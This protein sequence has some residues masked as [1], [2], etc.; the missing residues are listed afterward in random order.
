MNKILKYLQNSKMPDMGDFDDAN[1]ES[2]NRNYVEFISELDK[3]DSSNNER[4][5]S[6]INPVPRAGQIWI[7]KQKYTDQQGNLISGKIPYYILIVN[8]P[9][10]FGDMEFV[11]IQPLSIFTEFSAEDDILV[12]DASITGFKFL[13]ETWNEQPI[14][15][16]I[17]DR[18]INQLDI[19]LISEDIHVVL[20]ED[21]KLFRKIEIENSAYLRHSVVSYLSKDNRM[22]K[23]NSMYYYLAATA[24]LI[25]TVLLIWQPQKESDSKIIDKYL[26]AIAN[27]Y[28][29]D[30]IG[31]E[32][33]LRGEE[34]EIENLTW[35]EC[36]LARKAMTFYEK[37]NFERASQ[38]LDKLL[39]PRGKSN[40]LLFFL[41][42]S[43][44]KSGN[45]GGAI[46]NLKYLSTFESFIYNEQVDYYLAL[47][48]IENG[49]RKKARQLLKRIKD[50]SGAYSSISKNILKE[51]RWF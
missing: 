26:V 32:S 47:A 14:D 5:T 7:C 46:V 40:E 51:L 13:I 12:E 17:L 6:N 2:F 16:S 41:A 23:G 34:C 37:D 9:D 36:E 25:I 24:A 15:I 29:F 1:N 35:E 20:S 10:T 38:I 21:Q 42:I 48:Y 28:V 39:I 19:P 18:Y 3:L 49:D 43:Q 45:S 50:N 31:E 33:T 44:L 22:N 4:K 8:T 11:R 30:S 27:P